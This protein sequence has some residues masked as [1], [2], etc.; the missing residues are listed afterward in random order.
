MH[1]FGTIHNRMHLCLWKITKNRL[2][3]VKEIPLL[4][5]M[6]AKRTIGSAASAEEG[7][8]EQRLRDCINCPSVSELHSKNSLSLLQLALDAVDRALLYAAD[9]R[10]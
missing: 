6:S 2:P 10:L 3:L 7:V 1:N 4:G 8:A 5:E 9:L